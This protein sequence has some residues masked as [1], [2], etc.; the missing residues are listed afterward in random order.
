MFEL[1]VLTGLHQ[2]AALPLVGEQ[3]QIGSND[4][5]DLALHDMGVEPQHCRLQREGDRWIVTAEG[6]VVLDAE[7]HTHPHTVLHPNSPFVLGSVWLSIS[8]AGE[9]WPM[10][11]T[12]VPSAPSHAATGQPSEGS[13]NRVSTRKGV[14]L[15]SRSGAVVIGI[16]LGVVG[17]AWSLSQT[18]TSSRLPTEHFEQNEQVHTKHEPATPNTQRTRLS[19][20]EARLRLKNMLSDRLLNDITVEQMPQGL[21]LRGN[22]QDEMR[23]VYQRMLQ[24]FGEQYESSA[25][26]V[27][28]VSVGGTTLPFV[29]VQIMSGPQAHLVTAEG[30]RL[31]I[32][33]ELE[34][35]RLTR[36]DDGR[37][38]F[39]GERHYE[40]VW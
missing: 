18:G 21:V 36:I 32:G 9:A 4:D 3:W 28:Q 10:V 25:A 15:F 1:R 2:G 24:R 27:D 26:L 7:G 29:I 40:V 14:S 34:G 30:K 38:V 39:D 22:L 13:Q 8:P 5:L 23:P 33:D 35:L 17:S 6:G 37:V 20:E 31:Y 11:P 12:A 19:A 16:L